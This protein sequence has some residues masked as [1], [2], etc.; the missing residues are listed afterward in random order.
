MFFFVCVGLDVAAITKLVVET[1]RER[2]E[3]D[4]THHNQ[5]LE[6]GTTKVQNKKQTLLNTKMKKMC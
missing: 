2:D 3:T 1:V 4:F 5:M 6:M